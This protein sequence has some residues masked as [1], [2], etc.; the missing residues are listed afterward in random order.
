MSVRQGPGVDSHRRHL[1]CTRTPP[2]S[3]AGARARA[4]R[5]PDP[6]SKS[7]TLPH[8]LRGRLRTTRSS[9]RCSPAT[10][11]RSR[12]RPLRLRDVAL[13]PA[14]GSASRSCTNV[15]D[16]IG[17][18]GGAPE[19]LAIR[20][21]GFHV[22]RQAVAGQRRTRCCCAPFGLELERELHYGRLEAAKPAAAAHPINKIT[23]PTPRRGSGVAAA[24]KSMGTCARPA[25]AGAGRRGS[26]AL[27]IRL[28][29]IGLLWPMEAMIVRE[30]AQRPRSELFV[31][32]EKRSF[33]ETFISVRSSTTAERPIVVGK[34][35]EQAR[36]LVARQR[37]ARRRPDRPAARLA[38]R[39]E[40]QSRLHHRAGGAAEALR[41]R[42]A[43]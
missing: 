30:F 2:A 32:E 34:Q 43:R 35:D 17:T 16:E 41:E 19:R 27:R 22:G 28:L 26:A 6:L 37:R 9:R 25:R 5:R 38:P 10:C 36:T 14:C 20:D 42:P 21:P 7:S 3:A 33:V 8:A 12:P 31:V 4:G 15:A 39:E 13:L 23:V 11:R 24:G 40:A 1:K 18:R 29:Q